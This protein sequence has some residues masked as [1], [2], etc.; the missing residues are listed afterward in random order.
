MIVYKG[1]NLMSSWLLEAGAGAEDWR[2]ASSNKSWLNDHL[3]FQWLEQ[4]FEPCTRPTATTI[5]PLRCLLILDGYGSHGK[6][7]FIT[8]CMS[9]SIDLMV[10]PAY[11]SHRTQPLD[12]GVFGPLKRSMAR[13][14]DR[15]S[16]YSTR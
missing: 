13:A 8:F 1:Q 7:R 4:T 12:V 15:R 2:W 5:P 6:A 3:A 10:L 9:H 16:R 14:M 11:T